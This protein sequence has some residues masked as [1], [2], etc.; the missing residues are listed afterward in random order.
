MTRL[1]AEEQLRDAGV[2]AFASGTMPRGEATRFRRD[3]ESRVNG[4][5][6]ARPATINHLRS[7]GI[8]VVEVGRGSESR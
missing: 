6:R 8:Q 3:L 5:S 7:L 4:R 1:D 2:I